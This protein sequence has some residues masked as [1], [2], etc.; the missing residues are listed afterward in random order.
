[1]PHA[2]LALATTP[3]G[4]STWSARVARFLADVVG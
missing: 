3:S 2:E 1:M 4:L